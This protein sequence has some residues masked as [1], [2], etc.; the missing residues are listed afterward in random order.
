MAS[1]IGV[2]ERLKVD[3]VE[4]VYAIG[5]C[6]GYIESVGKPILPALAQV[7]LTPMAIVEKLESFGCHVFKY[8]CY[9]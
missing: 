2:D 1:R 9:V 4:D 3:G 8:P 7:P 5:D 6:A